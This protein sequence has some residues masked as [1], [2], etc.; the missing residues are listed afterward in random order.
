[1]DYWESG[2]HLALGSDLYDSFVRYQ[3]ELIGEYDRLAEEF[4]FLAVDARDSIDAIQEQLRVHIAAY[5]AGLGGDGAGRSRLA[6]G[7]RRRP[8]ARAGRR[9]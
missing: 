8:V 1:M 6:S 7:R 4:G 5:L 2:M 3:R 9:S